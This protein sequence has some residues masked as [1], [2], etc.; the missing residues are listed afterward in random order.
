MAISST[1]P[2][3]EHPPRL[4]RL[5][6]AALGLTLSVGCRPDDPPP[7]RPAPPVAQ[8][9]AAATSPA[10]Q[11]PPSAVP[12]A[13]ELAERIAEVRALPD[14]ADSWVTLGQAWVRT[15]RLAQQE[16][17]YRRAEA[18][19]SEALKRQPGH[20]GALHLQAMVHRVGHRFAEVKRVAADLVRRDPRDDTAWGLLADAA[21]ALGDMPTVERAIDRMLDLRPALPAFSRAAWLRWLHGDVDGA[22]EM[23]GEAL[24]SS[25]RTDPEPRAYV[26]TE[27]GH[28]QWHRG[29]LD[30]AVEAYDLALT[31]LPQ[32]AGALL[33]RGRVKLARKDAAGAIADFEAS[34]RARLAEQTAEWHGMALR[35]AGRTAEAEAVDGKLADAGAFDD[36]RS[37]ALYLNHRGLT[38]AVALARARTDFAQRQDIYAHDALGFALLRAGDLDAA[39]RHLTEATRWGTPDA[40]LL[41]HRGLL[42]K[43]RGRPDD[44]RVWLDRAWAL[45]R[46]VHPRLMVEVA[47]ARA[48]LAA[49]RPDQKD[50]P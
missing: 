20:A 27:I 44:A 28:L 30:A 42:E 3:I 21:L 22:L 13:P 16:A 41:A 31:A 33:G 5:A 36:P 11:M 29:R 43:A 34:N 46:H 48:A 8:P 49:D 24:K 37:I 17:L 39:A 50:A 32:H 2:S 25:G 23:W 14:R 10:L 38:P 9:A 19:A 45:N 1:A 26:L 12:T 18:A 47:A 40:M 6:W 7:P 4:R 35:A 15:A